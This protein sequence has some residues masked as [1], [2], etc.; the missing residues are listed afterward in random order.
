MYQ[1][2][3]GGP[4]G[5]RRGGKAM[6]LRKPRPYYV[7]KRNETLSVVDCLFQFAA[8]VIMVGLVV[9]AFGQAIDKHQEQCELAQPN[10]AEVVARW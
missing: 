8:L 2:A 7:S 3:E 9:M 4:Q 6:K 1:A 10:R 5:A